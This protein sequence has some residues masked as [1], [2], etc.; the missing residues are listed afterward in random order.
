MLLRS[1]MSDLVIKVLQKKTEG[2]MSSDLKRKS[3]QTLNPEDQ[4]RMKSV[5]QKDEIN[6]R[7]SWFRTCCCLLSDSA[8][9][10]KDWYLLI[11]EIIGQKF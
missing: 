7:S 2:Y 10:N 1:Q 8:P 9:L 5:S 4:L 3:V 11:K 6:F